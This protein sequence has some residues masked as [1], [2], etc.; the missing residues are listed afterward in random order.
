[1]GEA[2]RACKTIQFGLLLLLVLIMIA[3]GSTNHFTPASPGSNSGGPPPPSTG[4]TP[5]PTPAPQ[6]SPSPPPDALKK[7]NHIVFLIQENRSFDHYFGQLDQYRV[8]QG[9][10]A[11]AVD[12]LPP[13]NSPACANPGNPP[14]GCMPVN[15]IIPNYAPQPAFHLK[16]MCI[17]NTSNG[18][19]EA[20]QDFNLFNITSNTP[21]LDGFSW[22]AGGDAKYTGQLDTAGVR[23]MGYYDGN[24]LPYHYFLATQFATSDRFFSP[25]PTET[26][27]NKM[28][29]VAAT[30]VGHAHKPVQPV[31]AKTIFDLLEAAHISWKIYYARFPDDPIINYFQPFASQHQ[32]HI[33]PVSQYFADLKNGT[34]PSVAMIEPS[35]GSDDQHPGVGNHIQIGAANTA[36][37][38]N[39]LMTSQYWK[40][41]VFIMT[42]DEGGGMFD[43]VPPPTSGVPNPDGIKP[44]D[45]VTAP[46]ADPAG[47]FVRYGFRVPLIV[48]SP[49]SKRNYVSHTVTDSTAILRLIEARF[50]LPNLTKRDAIAIDMTE[51]FDF[52]GVPWATPPTPPAQPTTGPCYDALP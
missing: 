43:H 36:N 40:D 28:Y 48:V 24:D 23:A 47:D 44:V 19:Y 38:I 51:F 2:R 31:N 37:Y 20:W 13:E 32:D 16:T 10:K 5:T 11:G 7:L 21:M 27:P 34:L 17:E 50:G 4:P 45:L 18:W 46:P 12:G 39:S 8:T 30:S 29:L 1:M 25:A 15:P 33:V 35:F 22:S 9:L 42:F 3:C 49:F 41:S 6:G 26:E 52:N 14:N